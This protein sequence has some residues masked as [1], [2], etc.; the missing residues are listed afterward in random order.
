[1]SETSK[2]HCTGARIA[3]FRGDAGFIQKLSARLSFCLV[4][5]ATPSVALENLSCE[6]CCFIPLFFLFLNDKPMA[7]GL[8]HTQG[9]GFFFLFGARG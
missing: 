8:T 4:I 7:Y 2:H 1:M 3:V 5:T 9:R 6:G